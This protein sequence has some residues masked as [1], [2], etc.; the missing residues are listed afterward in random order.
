VTEIEVPRLSALIGRTGTWIA[1][2]VLAALSAFAWIAPRRL[3]NADTFVTDPFTVPSDSTFL[4]LISRLGSTEV[5]VAVAI[6][7]ALLLWNRCRP[8]AVLYPAAVL[9]G[10]ILNVALKVAIGRPRPP[11]S[12]TGT[13]LESF[14]SGHT[15]QA[16]IMLGMLPPAIL[17][18][19]GRRWI[20]VV[21]AGL[22]ALG[23]VAVAISRVGLGAHWVSDVVGGVLVGGLALLVAESLLDRL[24]P[25][26]LPDCAGCHIHSAWMLP[27]STG[28]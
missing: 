11:V 4:T 22:A 26:W 2:G 20:A 19:T 18:L 1:L 14:P 17:V 7:I 16:V 9:S 21:V 28:H 12:L 13:S 27:T 3:E 6:G 25:R 23:A 5:T 10:L 24:P 8:L 15:I